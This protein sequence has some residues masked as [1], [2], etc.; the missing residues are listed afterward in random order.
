[1]GI[2]SQAARKLKDQYWLVFGMGIFIHAINFSLSFPI[3]LL[4]IFNIITESQY[5]SVLIV[6]I[7]VLISLSGV[8][9]YGLC[10]V[11]LKISRLERVQFSDMFSGFGENFAS[12]VGT[13]L[14]MI[15][16]L[17]LWSLLLIIPGFVKGFAYVMTFYIK[18]DHPETKANAAMKSSD[19]LMKG[20]KG[21]LFGIY[22]FIYFLPILVLSF[23]PVILNN[24]HSYI[25]SSVISI[26]VNIAMLFFLPLINVITSDFYLH[27][28]GEDTT[29]NDLIQEES[30]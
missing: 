13:Y 1:M 23:I 30:I 5:V 3:R 14:L 25:A 2:V 20:H 18:I 29:E 26:I 6:Y 16:K 17:I 7:I 10:N 11:S 9:Y 12:S 28:K 4:D 15:L 22:L 21:E 24:F 8:L 19:S 27:V